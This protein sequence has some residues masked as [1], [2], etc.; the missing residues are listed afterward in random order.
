MSY[1]ISAY[2]ITVGTLLLYG[3]SLG[4]ER[5]RLRNEFEEAR[6]K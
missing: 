2:A 5:A 6:T 4:R 3:I 1:L